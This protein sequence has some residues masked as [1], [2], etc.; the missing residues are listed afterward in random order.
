MDCNWLV[1][2]C[3]RELFRDDSK[4]EGAFV[5]QNLE[6]FLFSLFLYDGPYIGPYCPGP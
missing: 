1:D 5:S 3:G 2:D 6:V 4:R